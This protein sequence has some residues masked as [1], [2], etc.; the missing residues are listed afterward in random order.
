MRRNSLVHLLALTVGFTISLVLFRIF[1]SG[2]LMY[3]FFGWNLFLAAV[4]LAISSFLVYAKNKNIQWLLF[5]LWLLFFP[6]SLY[7]VT[8]LLHLKARYPVPLWFD[9]VLVFSAAFNGLIIAYASLQRTELFLRT[10]FSHS[11]TGIII[12]ACLFV[13]SFGIY[14]GRFLRW[15]SWDILSDPLGLILQVTDRIFN[16]FEHPRTWGMTIV[17]TLFFSIYY[18]SIKKLPGLIINNK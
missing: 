3:I 11:R 8:D 14:L 17:F 15:N 18:F 5:A 13:S 7:I 1:Y 10:K 4:P 16:P 2:S 12:Y 6:N 9:S